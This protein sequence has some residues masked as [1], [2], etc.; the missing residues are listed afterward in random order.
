[1]SRA[2]EKTLILTDAQAERWRRAP[3]GDRT[4]IARVIAAERG[5]HL[6]TV[7]RSLRRMGITP[8][9]SGGR[10]RLRRLDEVRKRLRGNPSAA[11]R[12]ECLEALRA[13]LRETL[14]ECG[15]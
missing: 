7:Y 13:I 6:A 9:E 2:P 5:V 11:S 1:M 8:A 15:G 10:D 12:R 4:E 3:H 14:D